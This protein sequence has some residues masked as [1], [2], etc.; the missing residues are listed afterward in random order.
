MVKSPFVLGDRRMRAAAA[1]VGGCEDSGTR[2]RE[3]MA[4]AQYPATAVQRAAT[5][6]SQ[7]SATSSAPETGTGS[8]ATAPSSTVQSDLD[9]MEL[10]RLADKVYRSIEQRLIFERESMGL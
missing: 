8:S 3:G 4:M 9:E 6:G 10:E 5:N 1:P 2:E 7:S